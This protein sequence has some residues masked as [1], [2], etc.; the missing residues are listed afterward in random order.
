[1][2]IK[3]QEYSEAYKQAGV[4]TLAGQSLV[5]LIVPFARKTYNKNVVSDI[6][7]FSAVY[8]LSFLKEYKE[9]VLLTSTDGV[10][11]KLTYASFFGRYETIGYDLVAMCANDILVSGGK[12]HIFLDYLAVGKLHVQEMSI[13]IR[14]IAAACKMIECSLI[15]GETAEHPNVMKEND[16]DLAGFMIG[17]CE[18]EH[19]ITGENI[20]EGNV[21]IGIPSSGVHSNGLSLIRKLFYDPAS[22]TPPKDTIQKEMFD[23][24]KESILLQ[25]T[26]LYEKILYEHIKNKLIKG[27][28]HI[29]GGGYQENIPRILKE[30]YYVELQSW[31]LKTPF[32]EIQQ[33][34]NLSFLEMTNVFNCG[35][36]MLIFV[37]EKS[38]HSMIK[39]IS[40]NLKNYQ[41]NYIKIQKEFF[42]EFS[43]WESNWNLPYLSTE[44]KILGVVKKGA[45]YNKKVVFL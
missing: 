2:E 28:V 10:G 13:V 20:E 1:M 33:K 35:F 32:K 41:Q 22:N 17:F 31:D 45:K 23:F 15:G 34:G 37:D 18:R 30:N 5:K 25:P 9:P 39:Q 27:L 6:G 42:P 19:L 29:T 14:S 21:I 38:V 12:S 24:V 16:F 11:T 3:H 40:E 8:D 4:D 26:I 7:G 36:G 44:P 43:E